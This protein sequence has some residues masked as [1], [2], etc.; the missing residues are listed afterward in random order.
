MPISST[1][2][3]DNMMHAAI[4]DDAAVAIKLIAK[5]DFTKIQC[6]NSRDAKLISNR[7]SNFIFSRSQKEF[8]RFMQYYYLNSLVDSNYLGEIN[9]IFNEAYEFNDGICI[10]VI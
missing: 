9:K 8:N 3:T 2:I 1:P 4:T 5:A 7:L 10:T 6:V